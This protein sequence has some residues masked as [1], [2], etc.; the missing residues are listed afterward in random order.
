MY[1]YVPS[2]ELRN[3]TAGVIRRVQAGKGVVITVNGQPA[4]QLLP[5]KSGRRGWLSRSDLI[6]R[7]LTFQADAGL[8]QDLDRLAGETTDDLGQLA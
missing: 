1:E 8:R 4:A 3:D 7:I 2:R 5:M 6:S